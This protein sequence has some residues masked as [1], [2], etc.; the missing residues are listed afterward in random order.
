M[1]NIDVSAMKMYEK[2]GPLVRQKLPGEEALF[3]IM[4]PDDIATM[5]HHEGAIPT[6]MPLNGLAAV[7]A[8]RQMSLGLINE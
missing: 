2:Y 4:D 6:R 5:F 7:R 1:T 3:H 8:D